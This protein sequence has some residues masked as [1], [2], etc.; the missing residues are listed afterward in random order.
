MGWI[1]TK[2]KFSRCVERD[3]YQKFG[4]DV[5]TRSRGDLRDNAFSG[6]LGER[7]RRKPG[8]TGNAETQLKSIIRYLLKSREGGSSPCARVP[9]GSAFPGGFHRS[10][11]THNPSICH[12][13]II[14]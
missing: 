12:D 6:N 5:R 7:T 1:G 11:G 2:G 8:G 4:Y 9:Y 3:R 10:I 13:T 14:E